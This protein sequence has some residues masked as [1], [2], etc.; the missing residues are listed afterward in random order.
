MN[1]FPSRKEA[2]VFL[3]FRENIEIDTKLNLTKFRNWPKKLFYE[4]KISF[5]WSK[6]LLERTKVGRWYGE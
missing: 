3:F 6:V 1:F 2:L 5:S 4:I